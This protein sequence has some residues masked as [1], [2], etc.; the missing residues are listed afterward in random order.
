MGNIAYSY[1]D[2]DADI[3]KIVKQLDNNKID[4]VV[5]VYRGGVIPAQRLAYI[6][7][8]PCLYIK[9][10]LRDGIKEVGAVD[11]VA[12]LI[13]YCGQNVLIV[14]DISDS[15]KTFSEILGRIYEYQAQMSTE[16]KGTVKT[17]ALVVKEGTEF[18]PNFIGTRLPKDGAWVDF[19]WEQK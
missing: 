12:N 11:F 13:S 1:S 15:G 18:E 4:A 17:A 10:Q 3:W 14:D 6:L 2:F 5:G 9:W 8:C 19:W 16:I 7:E